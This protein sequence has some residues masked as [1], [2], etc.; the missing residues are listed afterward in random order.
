MSKTSI[1]AAALV[2]FLTGALSPAANAFVPLQMCATRSTD[3]AYDENDWLEVSPGQPI[4]FLRATMP[5]FSKK[6]DGHDF[7]AS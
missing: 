2:A 6:K 3:S 7:T 1:T 4:M 5:Q